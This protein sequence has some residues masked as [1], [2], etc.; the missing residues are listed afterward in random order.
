MDEKS[1]INLDSVAGTSLAVSRNEI[2]GGGEK[3][4]NREKKETSGK[5][6]E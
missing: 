6:E 4:M 2:R 3:V 5:L 1:L